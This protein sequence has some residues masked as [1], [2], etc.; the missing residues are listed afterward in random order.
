MNSTS[1]KLE[2][3]KLPDSAVPTMIII[4]YVSRITVITCKLKFEM[5]NILKYFIFNILRVLLLFLSGTTA[6]LSNFDQFYNSN[7]IQNLIVMINL[8]NKQKIYSLL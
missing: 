8:F 1:V 4:R 7:F 2:F 3:L 6:L 5:S